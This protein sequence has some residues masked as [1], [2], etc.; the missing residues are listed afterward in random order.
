MK[1]SNWFKGNK[2]SSN[3]SKEQAIA[4]AKEECS[5]HDIFEIDPTIVKSRRNF[6]VVFTN[7]DQKGGNAIITIQKDTGEVTKFEVAPR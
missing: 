3:I 4:I 1:L 7:I 5:K 2:S 6:F